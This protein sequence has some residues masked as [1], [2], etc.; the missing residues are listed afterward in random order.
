MSETPGGYAVHMAMRQELTPAQ[1]KRQ[2]RLDASYA[3]AQR[4]LQDRGFVASLRQRL[5]ELDAEPRPP[6]LSKTQFLEQTPLHH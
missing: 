3:A 4:R 6:R 2:A 5:T 1:E